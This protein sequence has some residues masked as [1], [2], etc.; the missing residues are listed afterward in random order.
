VA[1]VGFKRGQRGVEQFPF[2]DDD[3]VVARGD[4]VS[5]E[6]LTDQTFSQVSLNG[7]AELFRGRDPQPSDRAL[8]GEDEYRGEAP[9]DAGAV[10]VH[11]LELGAAADVFM[12][13]EPGQITRC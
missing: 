7:A 3:D 6:N 1:I 8:V 9:V 13:P 4:V 12:R 11:V 2:R 5:T 10:L